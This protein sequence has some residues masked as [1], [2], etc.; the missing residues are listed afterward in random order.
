MSARSNIAQALKQKLL[1][2]NGS[3]QFKSTIYN[4]VFVE[5]KFWDECNDF[6]AIFVV[7]GTET[8]EYEPGGFKWGFLNI[9]IKGYVKAEE[10]LAELENLIQD[11]EKVIDANTNLEYDNT[12]PC[13]DTTDIKIMSIVT[14][15]GLLKPFG[16]AE[17]MIQVQYQVL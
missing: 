5:N 1:E 15:E 12:N 6:P 10:P 4:N 2:I 13:G 7:P 17:I 9:A 11:V 8:R 16:V 3:P 14:D